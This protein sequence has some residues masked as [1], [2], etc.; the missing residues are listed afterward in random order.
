MRA[1]LDDFTSASHTLAEMKVLL[2]ELFSL[3][4]ELKLKLHPDKCCLFLRN[5]RLLGHM[6]TEE[7]IHPMEKLLQRIRLTGRPQNKIM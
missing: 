5:I 3:C 1:Y 7:G 4:R 6:L 2:E